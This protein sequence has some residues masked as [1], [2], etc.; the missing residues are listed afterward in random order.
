M[1]E[2]SCSFSFWEQIAKAGFKVAPEED[3]NNW[4]IVEG[5]DHS[6]S[7]LWRRKRGA[8]E[9]FELKENIMYLAH[10]YYETERIKSD[11]VYGSFGS[12]AT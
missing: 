7:S 5:T 10:R 3:L 8:P 6:D 12:S 9:V 1:N 11:G 4:I 2:P